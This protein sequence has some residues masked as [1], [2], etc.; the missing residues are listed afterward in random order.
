MRVNCIVVREP[1]WHSSHHCRLAETLADAM[2]FEGTPQHLRSENGPAIL[3][4]W[5]SGLG[6]KCL[7]IEPGS[8]RKNGLYE[9]PSTANFAT[10]ASRRDRV[11]RHGGSALERGGREC[12]HHIAPGEPIQNAFIESFNARL[13]NELLNEPLFTSLA[14]V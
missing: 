11:H 4:Q 14:Q 3:R 9:V 5:L 12:G 6:T 10:N 7:Y 2:L 13:R 1:D 8:P